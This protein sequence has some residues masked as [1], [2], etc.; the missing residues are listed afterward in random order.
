MSRSPDE[1]G[2]RP[3][4]RRCPTAPARPS[5]TVPATCG[6]GARRGARARWWA[7]DAGGRGGAADV[8]AVGRRRTGRSAGVVGAH[9]ARATRRAAR[10]RASSTRLVAARPVTTVGSTGRGRRLPSHGDGGARPD[11]DRLARRAAVA[12]DRAAPGDDPAHLRQRRALPRRLGRR[13]GAPRRRPRAGRPG[14]AAVHEQGRPAG[15]LPVRDVRGAARAGGA[16]ARVQRYDGPADRRR[17]HRRRHRHVG[18]GDGAQHPRRRRPA[19]RRAAQRL[20]LR[21]VHRRPRRALR[22]REARLHRRT[23]LRRHDRAAGPADHRL[24]ARGSSW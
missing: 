15:Q 23:G 13:R 4:G 10:R 8:A 5:T 2:S 7:V 20:R 22:R 9:P 11:R 16:G 6:S 19:G 14:E 17:L 18:H 21:A 12:A 3:A 1:R 24:R